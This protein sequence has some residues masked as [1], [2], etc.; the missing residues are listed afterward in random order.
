MIRSLAL[1]CIL[2]LAVAGCGGEGSADAPAAVD[3]GAAAANSAE[4]RAP[5]PLPDIVR[6]R[7]ETDAGTIVVAL[8]ARRA[9]ITT[10]NFVRY[11]DEERFDGTTFYRASRTPGS[12]GRG[13]IQGGIRRDV[14]RMFPA[15]LHEPTSETGLTHREGT[16]SMARAE[17][18]AGAIGDFFITASAMPT[19]DAR[20][21]SPG[22]AAFGRVVEGMDVVRRILA[23][24]TVANAG[25]GAMRG[26]MLSPTIRIVSARRVD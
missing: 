4:P 2:S 12:E 15:I 7:L 3:N 18:G 5:E 6:V 8:D 17:T 22:Y 20:R 10:A 24:P 14:R 13:F 9:P 16:I 25:R 26:Q 19:L 21:G 23:A 1:L 11:V